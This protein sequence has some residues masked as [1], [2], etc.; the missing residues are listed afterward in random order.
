MIKLTIDGKDIKV[1]EGTMVLKAAEALGIE[2]PTMCYK[3]GFHCHPSCMVCLVKDAKSG[4]FVPSCAMPV[5]ENMQIIASD[6]DVKQARRDALELLLSDHVG[7]CDAPCRIGCPAYMNIP[8]MN[9]LI[10]KGDFEQANRVVKEEIAIPHILGY[11]CPAPCE[12]VCRRNTVDTTISICQLKKFVSAK[13]LGNGREYFPEKNQSSGKKVAIIGSG[14]AGLSAAFHLL[15]AGHECII[16]DK[17]ELAGGNLRYE[18]MHKALPAEVLDSEIEYLISYGAKF[19]LN[20]QIKQNEFEKL[21][22]DYD[23]VL[24]AS[25]T[26]PDFDLN[27]K[28]GE[29]GISVYPDTYETSITKVFACGG[30]VKTLKMAVRA[31]AQ[32]KGA[33]HS[34]EAFL[35]GSKIE[36]IHRQFNSKFGKLAEEEFDE[37]LKEAPNK[38]NKKVVDR[39]EAYT[40]ED[41]QNEAE[42]CM[43][44]D[45]RKMD[46]CKLRVHSDKYQVDRR[47]Y[48]LGDRQKV[49]KFFKQ[50]VI[51]YEPEK[52]IKCGLCVE[53]TSRK[54]EEVGFTHI[55]RGFDVR[56]KA[57]FGKSIDKALTTTAIE[58]AEACPTGAISKVVTNSK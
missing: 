34:I 8:L 9:R 56:I 1:A 46:N 20:S 4:K 32:A 51:V 55:G 19:I 25:G 50:D 33:A 18:T 13:D 17:N 24:I 41:A 5:S 28:M 29:K 36:K 10:A 37:Y 22:A 12:K 23:A 53:I 30:A 3:E 21:V 38:E 26:N 54:K 43:H 6:E 11:I 52:C 2:I 47:K 31:L 7:D 16:Y 15:K 39:L 44:C 45:C 57:P 49:S 35:N 48:L 27:V 58:C 42:R 14:P 40:I